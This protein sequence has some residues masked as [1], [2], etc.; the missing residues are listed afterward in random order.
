MNKAIEVY[1]DTSDDRW[2]LNKRL[3]SKKARNV[4]VTKEQKILNQEPDRL[5][6][7]K[8]GCTEME[9]EEKLWKFNCITYSVAVAW[10]HVNGDYQRTPWGRKQRPRN[11]KRE[12]E[13]FAGRQLLS[14]ASGEHEAIQKQ[15]KVTKR[16]VK[17]RKQISAKCKKNSN[18]NSQTHS[19]IFMMLSPNQNA[20]FWSGG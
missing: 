2:D 5:N 10:R 20:S 7:K 4:P 8:V 15:S 3:W 19:E 16:R 6:S 17:R 18:S 13:N 14:K 1:N 12:K 9:P 11:V